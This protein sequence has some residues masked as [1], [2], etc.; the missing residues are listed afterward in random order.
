MANRKKN[1]DDSKPKKA[2]Q[3]PRKDQADQLATGNSNKASEQHIST[4]KN[5]HGCV[6]AWLLLCLVANLVTGLILLTTAIPWL[7][8]GIVINVVCLFALFQ[9]KKWGF[10]GIVAMTIVNF[11]V[12]LLLGGSPESAI[13]GLAGIAILYGLLQLGQPKT[14]WEQLE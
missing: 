3:K 9:W 7:A 6:V 12:N 13:S 1:A 4:A 2:N 14:G 10:Y 8:A 11:T 5:H